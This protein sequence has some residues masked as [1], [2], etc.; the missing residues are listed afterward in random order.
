VS[1]VLRSWES[2][3]VE[4]TR[5]IGR[6][7]ARELGTE[8]C[9]LLLGELGA[10]KTALVQGLAAGLG[11]DPDRIQSPTF[12]LLA[13][14]RGPAGTLLHLDL[15]RVEAE[16]IAAAGFEEALLG[17]GVKAVEWA[18]RLPFGVPG[19]RTVRIVRDGERRRIEEIETADLES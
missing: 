4:E 5:E 9:L 16:E 1:R 18:E 7:L 3:S 17:A 19:A 8:G 15:Y 12:T 14:H 10:G 13:E 6:E 2:T 11:L